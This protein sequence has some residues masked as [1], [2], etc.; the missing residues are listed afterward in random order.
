VP[1]PVDRVHR[2]ASNPKLNRDGRFTGL[3][4]DGRFTNELL[5]DPKHLYSVLKDQDPKMIFVN[6]FS[7]LLHEALPMELMLEHVRVFKAA[8]WHQFQV[9]TKRSQRLTELNDAILAEFAGWPENLWQRVSVCSAARIEMQRIEHLGA[10][11]AA[12]EWIPFEPWVSDV[13][14]P[15]HEAAPNL[16]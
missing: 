11:E 16:R 7:D 14:I 6:E 15:L 12:L 13:N 2:H 8:C 3:V 10:T 1:L 4:D 5:F 9:L